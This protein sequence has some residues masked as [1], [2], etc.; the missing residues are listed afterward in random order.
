MSAVSGGNA[1]HS[2]LADDLQ[3]HR[4]D[5]LAETCAIVPRSVLCRSHRSFRTRDPAAPSPYRR[6]V[7][8]TGFVTP[9]SAA[10]SWSRSSR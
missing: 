6:L 7:F 1:S 9:R 5:E 8:S 4:F 2:R 10:S 3:L